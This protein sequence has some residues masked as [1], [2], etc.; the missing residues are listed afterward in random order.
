VRNGVSEDRRRRQ[1]ARNAGRSKLTASARAGGN[2][3]EK[4][5]E[6]LEHNLAMA[7]EPLLRERL[8]GV[9]RRLR[10]SRGDR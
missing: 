9:I 10:G 2:S 8:A 5:I 4:L 1:R 6:I 7:N 3:S